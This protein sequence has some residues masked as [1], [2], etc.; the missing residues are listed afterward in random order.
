[1]AKKIDPKPTNYYQV[2]SLA[3]KKLAVRQVLQR[4]KN[5][6]FR[7]NT[8]NLQRQ[9]V[10][11]L[12]IGRHTY[13][14]E[15]IA[16]RFGSK[17]TSVK[18]GNFCSIADSITIF[19]GGNHRVD[20]ISTYPFSEFSAT[21]PNA[22]S[23]TGHPSSKGS[24]TIGNDVWIGSHATIMSGVTVGDGAV[25]GAYSVVTK[26]VKPYSIVV[27]N[28]AVHK[29]F[30]FTNNQVKKLQ[31]IKWWDWSDDKINQYVHYLC[32]NE[33]NKFFKKE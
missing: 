2:L 12:I 24:V 27:G 5:N 32:K 18:I 17:D 15:H 3:T 8:N 6:I 11:N 22:I 4:T 31:E 10:P 28:P 30:R 1:M 29:K 14:E 19:L 16:V 20:W 33:L 7:K 25:I 9:H 26:D 13:G 23:I 21:W